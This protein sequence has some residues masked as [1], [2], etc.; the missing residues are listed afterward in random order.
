MKPVA[1]P[2]AGDYM[3]T[4]RREQGFCRGDWR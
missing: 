1:P 3:A 2:A 4:G